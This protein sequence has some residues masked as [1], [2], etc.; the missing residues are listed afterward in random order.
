MAS[1]NNLILV[2]GGL[3]ILVCEMYICVYIYKYFGYCPCSWASN[4]KPLWYLGHFFLCT[5][6]EYI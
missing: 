3:Y 6:F 5:L 4:G 1:P 2:R